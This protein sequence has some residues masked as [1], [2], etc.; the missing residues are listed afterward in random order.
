MKTKLYKFKKVISNKKGDASYVSVVI[1]MFVILVFFATFLGYWHTNQ[2]IE[3]TEENIQLALDN[4]LMDHYSDLYEPLANGGKDSKM[5]EET[6]KRTF[7]SIFDKLNVETV[8]KYME[9][10]SPYTITNDKDNITAY[11]TEGDVAF[12]LN[13]ISLSY[14]LDSKYANGNGEVNF[15]PKLIADYKVETVINL[16]L[17]K[18]TINYST[19]S[20]SSYKLKYVNEYDDNGTKKAESDNNTP[21]L[22]NK[23]A[24]YTLHYNDNKTA[25]LSDNYKPS[26]VKNLPIPRRTNY[27]FAGWYRSTV[28]SGATYAST[29]S[30]YEGDVDYYAKWVNSYH[31]ISNEVK[32]TFAY[33]DIV[34]PSTIAGSLSSTPS[35]YSY[36]YNG[37]PGSC[38]DY[39]GKD[40]QKI[41]FSKVIKYAAENT[42]DPDNYAHS[43]YYWTSQAE[44]EEGIQTLPD[45]HSTPTTNNSG[46][47]VYENYSK[48][49]YH[50]DTYGNPQT[51]GEKF[52]TYYD[53]EGNEIPESDIYE[54]NANISEVKVWYVNTLKK[55]KVTAH[56]VN[57]DTSEFEENSKGLF[58]GT[59]RVV[60]PNIFYQNPLGEINELAEKFG[61]KNITPDLITKEKFVH[62]N[63]TYY[64]QYWSHDKEGN[65]IVSAYPRY[66]YRV[67]SNE[68]LY[69]IYETKEFQKIG[70]STLSPYVNTYTTSNNVT[71]YRIGGVLTPYNCPDNDTNIKKVGVLF[72]RTNA[73]VIENSTD[74]D[75]QRLRNNIIKGLNEGKYAENTSDVLQA[76]I[77]PDS[78][79]IFTSTIPGYIYNAKGRLNNKNKGNFTINFTKKT[80]KNY[81]MYAIQVMYYDA[82]NPL[83]GEKYGWILGDNMIKYKFDSNCNYD[84]TSIQH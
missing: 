55:Y 56:I 2:K 63:N 67:H 26:E 61:V 27:T 6:Y 3:L 65:G 36:T 54:Q 49:T 19:E 15:Q 81:S 64:F 32:V 74:E 17:V 8:A 1:V 7:Q 4:Y 9:K 42:R 14:K 31:E 53:N 71:T 58:V 70:L 29:P 40:N 60:I 24:K 72:I 34:V 83:T 50:P 45:Y 38:F 41:N 18:P 62:N 51:S 48:Q 57:E 20:F 84:I 11:D 76:K 47:W 39:Y 68:T 80:I 21:D 22:S 13:D 25:N 5:T 75:C 66:N 69:A 46:E 59:K 79:Q 82:I 30:T 73:D 33:Y 35:T 16:A 23:T 43:Y 44:A 10:N 12:K 78:D 37:L 52:V 77:F 28:L